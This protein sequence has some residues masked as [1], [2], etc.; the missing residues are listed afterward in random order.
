MTVLQSKMQNIQLCKCDFTSR[1]KEVLSIE[2]QNATDQ[3]AEF[4][5]C[6]QANNHKREK[7]S[8]EIH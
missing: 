2:V 4:R 8:I 5:V 6:V 1:T 7:N 3:S